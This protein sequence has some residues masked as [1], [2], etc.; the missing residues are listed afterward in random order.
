[1]FSATIRNGLLSPAY[2]CLQNNNNKAPPHLLVMQVKNQWVQYI[3]ILINNIKFHFDLLPNSFLRELD[4]VSRMLF[5]KSRRM[6]V[7]I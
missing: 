7:N 4:F 2:Y 5:D 1:M 3:A 6:V